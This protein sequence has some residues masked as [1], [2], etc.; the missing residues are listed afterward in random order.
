M[1]KVYVVMMNTWEANLLLGV[2]STNEK[3]ESYIKNNYS[4]YKY[5]KKHGNWGISEERYYDNIDI[6]EVIVDA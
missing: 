4:S 6:T 3:A 2:F 5:R 1:S